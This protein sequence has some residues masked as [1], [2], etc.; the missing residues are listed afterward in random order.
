MT[1]TFLPEWS[2]VKAVLLAWPFP[3]G[4]WRNNYPQVVSCYWDMLAAI[5]KAAPIWLLYHPKLNLTEMQQGLADR[6]IDPARITVIHD[7]VY[8]DTW[9]R[10]YGPLS[11]DGNYLT[12]TFNG[13]GGKYVSDND[14]RVPQQLARLLGQEPVAIPFVTEGGGLETNGRELLANA[15]CLVD[16]QRNPG[17]SRAEVEG[18][19]LNSLELKRVI[20]FENIVLSGDDTD[21]HI[22]TIV[23]FAD[24]S[25][26]VYAGRNSSHVDAPLLQSLHEQVQTIVHEMG[27]RAFELPSSSYMSLVDGRPLPC[28]YANFLIAN[29]HVFAPIYG[30]PEDQQAVDVLRQAF[31]DFEVVPVRCEA[32]L[33][34]HGSLHCSTMQVAAL[35]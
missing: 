20:W 31:P 1:R 34:Q 9:I 7:I 18:K 14:N 21:G 11:L 17:L 28:T 4:T 13:W 27:W 33:E 15:N 8:D 24:E 3:G 26:L 32:L 30:L 22:D 19:L 25:T 5:S 6:A 29:R 16:E 35:N 23:R 12:F 2:P 10:D